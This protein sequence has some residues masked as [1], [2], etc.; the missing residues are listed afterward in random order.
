MIIGTS[1]SQAPSPATDYLRPQPLLIL[2][3][4]GKT[5]EGK[6]GEDQLTGT[7]RGKSAGIRNRSWGR[8]ST[9]DHLSVWAKKQVGFGLNGWRMDLLNATDCF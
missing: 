2:L 7:A 5:V 1:K 3:F 6:E 8:I 4:L 9:K